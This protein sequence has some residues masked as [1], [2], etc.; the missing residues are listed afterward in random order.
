MC[1]FLSA[2]FTRPGKLICQPLYT[3]S[4]SELMEWAGIRERET[5]APVQQ[6]VRLELTPPENCSDWLDVANWKENIDEREVPE[7]FDKAARFDAF[8]QMRTIIAESITDDPGERLVFGKLMIL[9][10]EAKVKVKSSRVFLLDNSTATLWDNSTATLWG[11]STATLRENST[12]T[13]REKAKILN[14]YRINKPVT[15]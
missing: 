15:A 11:N 8:E 1:N 2:L 4:H 7:W 9:R 6:F 10:G 12:A 3:D 5:T 13:L 14:D